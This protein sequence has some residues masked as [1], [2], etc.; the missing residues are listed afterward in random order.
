MFISPRTSTALTA[1]PGSTGSG[2]GSPVTDPAPITGTTPAAANL[3]PNTRIVSSLNP[4]NTSG[5]SIGLRRLAYTETAAP[6]STPGPDV[7]VASVAGLLV[8]FR[9]DTGLLSNSSIS[10]IVAAGVIPAIGS[11]EK[12]PI[13]Y[14]RAPTS[15]PSMYTGLP[16][17]PATTPVNSTLEPWSRARITSD[18][19]PAMSGRTPSISTSTGSGLV[20]S[21]TVYATPCM[22]AFTWLSGMI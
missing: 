20:P 10:S 12:V 22:P 17:M 7:R 9:F 19:G 1:E 5:A 11:F 8:A 15:L 13:R 6:A 18:F 16:L 3:S 2:C 4:L 14:A 21:N